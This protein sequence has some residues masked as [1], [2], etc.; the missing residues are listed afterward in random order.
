MLGTASDSLVLLRASPPIGTTEQA[1]IDNPAAENH[2]PGRPAVQQTAQPVQQYVTVHSGGSFGSGST[3]QH[4]AHLAPELPL[5]AVTAAMQPLQSA[6]EDPRLAIPQQQQTASADSPAPTAQATLSDAAEAG[7]MSLAGPQTEHTHVTPRAASPAAVTAPSVQQPGSL[8]S[9]QQPASAGAAGAQ[10]HAD[11]LPTPQATVTLEVQAPGGT[12]VNVS[13]AA[14]AQVHADS[15]PADTCKLP[16]AGG[17]AADEAHADSLPAAQ[18]ADTLPLPAGGGTAVSI[19][20]AA[21]AQVHAD[22]LPAA[23]AADTFK[24]PAAGVNVS[25]A[26]G[27]QVHVDSLPAALAAD[28]FKAPAAAGTAAD[29]SESQL[30]SANVVLTAVHQA[31]RPGP[32]PGIGMTA[33]L[34]P[35]SPEQQHAAAVSVS[36]QEQAACQSTGAG[37]QSTAA[38]TRQQTLQKRTKGKKPKPAAA[39]AA[40]TQKS[41]S[42]WFD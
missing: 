30:G 33:S 22:S 20:K 42:D 4:M 17:T 41:W 37:E 6:A 38:L 29:V 18:A 19:S 27:A 39:P 26:A 13:K 1:S 34:P 15:L 21:G 5:T 8:S 40:Q 24:L 36:S 7:G 25:K 31:A 23:R 9:S 14:G 35:S 10:V 2:P 28:A 11:S 3:R 16:A 12:A 32:E